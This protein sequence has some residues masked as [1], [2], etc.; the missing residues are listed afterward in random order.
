MLK[1]PRMVP[2]RIPISFS[3]ERL[4]EV[5]VSGEAVEFSA[6]EFE[7]VGAWDVV[8]TARR[9][10]EI[11]VGNVVVVAF[12]L[13]DWLKLKVVENA[14]ENVVALWDT[15]E[16]SG[17]RVAEHTQVEEL[18]WQQDVVV[19]VCLTSWES[20]LDNG[21]GSSSSLLSIAAQSTFEAG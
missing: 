19:E 14:V 18:G 5:F 16:E 13:E 11:G 7:V 20:A 6:P 10:G 4:E 1:L 3:R 9:R 2:I 17:A 8:D 12:E 21:A 15:V